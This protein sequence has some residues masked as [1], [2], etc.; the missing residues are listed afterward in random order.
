M[1]LTV[2]EPPNWS[3]RTWSTSMSIAAPFFASIGRTT[4]SFFASCPM[5]PAIRNLELLALRSPFVPAPPRTNTASPASLVNLAGVS[6]PL[7]L[8]LE[9]GLKLGGIGVAHVIDPD[10]A[11]RLEVPLLARWLWHSQVQ[12]AFLGQRR[13]IFLVGLRPIGALQHLANA[14]QQQFRHLDQAADVSLL[15][16]YIDFPTG[17]RLAV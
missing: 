17:I 15:R 12:P 5:V 4:L 9:H 16:A 7:D 1:L 11:C 8:G 6:V 14:W 10:V 2:L 3:S 13:S